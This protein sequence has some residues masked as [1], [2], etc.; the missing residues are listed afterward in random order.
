MH[1][2]NTSRIPSLPV[3]RAANATPTPSTNFA[4]QSP[5][6]QVVAPVPPLGNFS[7]ALGWPIPMPKSDQ[8]S[9]RSLLQ[10]DASG[11]PGLPLA[12]GAKGA[13]G[14]LL[15]GSAVSELDLKTPGKALE[16]L[17]GSPKAQ[18]LGQAIQDKLAGIATDTSLND[19][20]L[21]AIHLGLDPESREGALP[22]SVAGFDLA[23]RSYWG[24]PAA[25]VIQG[26]A[27]H[28]VTQGRATR[29]TAELAAQLL[30]AGQAPEF[31]VK[32]VPSSVTCGSLLWTQFAIATAKLEANSPGRVLN[33]S[34]SEVLAAA[35]EI[36][37]DSPGVQATQR[38]ALALWAAVN[39]VVESNATPLGEAEM[40]RIRLAYNR[41]LSALTR[42]VT[43]LQTEVPDRK[44]L[45]LAQLTAAFPEVDASVFEARTLQKAWLNSG[46]PGVFPGMRSM[47]DI[48]MEG[49]KLGDK[50]HWISQD[51][52]IP[53]QR[54]CALCESG[55]LDVSGAFASAYEQSIKALESGHKGLVLYLISTLP[56]EDRLNFEYGRLEF[57]H[58]NDYTMAMDFTTPLAL[59]KRGHTL[60][61][62]VTRDGQTHIY[63]LDTRAFSVKKRDYL[64]STYTPPYTAAKLESRVANTVSKTVLFDP[65]KDQAH[66]AGEKT[67][68]TTTPDSLG[69]QRS[70][71]IAKVFAQSLDMHN[72]DLLNHARGYTSYDQGRARN[73]AIGEFFL[74]LIPLRSA[75]V[76]FRNGNVGA[77]LFDLGLDVIGLVTLGA[78]K[79]AQAGKVLAK[80]ISS[81]G[82]VTKAVRFLG[83]TAIEAFNP[84]SGLGDLAK[85]GVRLLGQGAAKG[86]ET[87]NKLRGASGS[88]DLLKAASKHYGEAATGSLKVA[89]K[90]TEN[91]AVLHNGKWY[92]F[93][94]DR[95]RPYGAPLDGFTPRIR[96]VDGVIKA[97]NIEPARA[98]SNTQFA[99]YKVPASRIA[100]LTPDSRGVYVAADGHLAHIRHTDS[101][102]LSAVY[103]VRQ[104]TRTAE[105][106]VQARVY[107]NNR[108]TPLLVEHV[109]GDQWQR[110]G[111]LGGSPPSVKADLGPEIGRGGEGIVYASLDGKSVYKDLGPTRLT[112]AEGHINMEVVNLNKYYGE[113]FAAVMVDEGRK[114]IKMGRIDG[115]DLSQIEKGSLPA[116]AR[117]LLDDVLAQM[118]AKD[119]FHN[120]P[121]L[122]NFMY[123]AKD[124]KIYPVDMDALS[125][126]FMVPGVSD[127]YA[128]KKD[129]VRREFSELLAKTA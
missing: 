72:D 33:M 104:V 18:A 46:R 42:S 35:E 65:F 109:Q 117:S 57:F 106:A 115:V 44:A 107:H 110:L 81:V 71:Y 84:L 13:L 121:Q 45:A 64:K 108:Q 58:T 68:Q 63:E 88:Y 41:Q 90:R 123:S 124:Q 10:S 54:F 94:P 101:T 83:A 85:G 26:L 1:V 59:K 40:E 114:Y 113:G 82:A 30:L 96:A 111:A 126:E 95:M 38:N 48:V 36:G 76:N 20:L 62:K 34:Y 55:K 86:V 7:G 66:R 6:P 51:K 56:P 100:G 89:G 22:N 61:V 31:L 11:L 15:S 102:G 103:E 32:G 60:D 69:S 23:Q 79:A 128:R 24:A 116:H 19:Y 27:G 80:G 43:L 4:L 49:D 9:L 77:G 93:D 50:E 12:E 73:D 28:L 120:D 39:G 8:D 37:A 53:I 119:I 17:L 87:V 47:L 25:A 99:N 2:I 98:L 78:G 75:I 5:T 29:Q 92:G 67:V 70:H 122:S 118:E 97:A 129:K 112:T 14:Y 3:T 21:A 52:R 91:G 125:A 127:V 16:K 105:G 74:N